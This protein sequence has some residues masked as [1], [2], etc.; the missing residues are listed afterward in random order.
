[1]TASAKVPYKVASPYAFISP[2]TIRCLLAQ[3]ALY[4]PTTKIRTV[5]IS[6]LFKHG[7]KA[8][9]KM[10][11]VYSGSIPMAVGS[12]SITAAREKYS[13]CCPNKVNKI[14]S[15][16]IT[17]TAYLKTAKRIY[18]FAPKAAFRNT[19]VMDVSPTT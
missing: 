5:L 6:F 18:G 10:N 9:M 1:M 8:F 17:S 11:M 14:H 4:T 3:T 15:S 12:S 13:I 19:A 7:Y 2:K 16:I